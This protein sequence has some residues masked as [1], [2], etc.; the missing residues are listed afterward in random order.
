M[1]P[2]TKQ[3][4]CIEW[5]EEVLGCTFHVETKEEA[6]AFIARYMDEAKKAKKHEQD[7][8]GAVLDS[9]FEGRY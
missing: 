9:K 4:S 3:V 2:T 1:K 7:L 5:M 8:R 6:Q